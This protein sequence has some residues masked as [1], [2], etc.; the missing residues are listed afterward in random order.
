MKYL[1]NEKCV[2]VSSEVVPNFK[3]EWRKIDDDTIVELD[4]INRQIETFTC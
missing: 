2:V 4:I 3:A 1:Q